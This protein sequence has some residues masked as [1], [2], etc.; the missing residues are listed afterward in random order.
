MAQ[1]TPVR[2]PIQIR[3]GDLDAMGHI[4]N[5]VFITYFE[6]ARI[7]YIQ[8]LY[9]DPGFEHSNNALHPDFQIILGEVTCRFRS[10]GLLSDLLVVEILA[11][12]I[13]RKSFVFEYRI[14]DD[15][16]GRLVAEG[17]STQVW[18]DYATGQT[19]DIPN[20][21]VSDMERLQGAPIPRRSG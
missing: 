12:E 13:G 14:V 6:H 20:S 17:R 10:P 15:R 2:V 18:Y 19:R 3:W 8:A 16:G 4:N 1:G 5:A 7:G 11:T 21:V 9:P